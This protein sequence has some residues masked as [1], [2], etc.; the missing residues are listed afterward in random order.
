MIGNVNAYRNIEV[1]K[2]SWVRFA[3]V[4]V[5]VD[6]L[7]DAKYAASGQVNGGESHAAAAGQ[8]IFFS[9]YGRAIYGGVT[10]GLF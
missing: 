9:G 2:S 5:E 6:N 8:Q 4:F 7:E 3:K 1:G 10:L